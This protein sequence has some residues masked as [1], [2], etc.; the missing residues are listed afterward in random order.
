MWPWKKRKKSINPNEG[1]TDNLEEI[2]E[3][4]KKNNIH[5]EIEMKLIEK[6]IVGFDFKDKQHE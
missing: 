4:L 6:M 3:T 1:I 5:L 2:A